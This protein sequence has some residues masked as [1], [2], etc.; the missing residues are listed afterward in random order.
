RYRRLAVLAEQ[1]A[2]RGQ[3]APRTRSELG[4]Q[5]RTLEGARR[6]AHERGRHAEQRREQALAHALALE[7]SGEG[8]GKDLERLA[9]RLDGQLLAARYENLEVEEARRMQAELGPLNAAIVVEDPEQAAAAICSEKHAQES[10]WLVRAG[11]WPPPDRWNLPQVAGHVVVDFGPGLRVTRLPLNVQLGRAARERRAR[12]L[13]EEAEACANEHDVAERERVELDAARAELEQ[14]WEH[15]EIWSLGDPSQ[16]IARTTAA[17]ASVREQSAEQQRLGRAARLEAARLLGQYAAGRPFLGDHHLLD[18][19]EHAALAEAAA[20]ATLL[21]QL[22]LLDSPVPDAAE[23]P[24][25]RERAARLDAQSDRLF[26]VAEALAAIAGEPAAWAWSAAPRALAE[27]TELVPELEAQHERAQLEVGRAQGLFEGAEAAWEAATA[28]AQSASA[29]RASAE[30]HLERA[31]AELAAEGA[32]DPASGM[33]EQQRLELAARAQ[34]VERL[35][36]EERGI[37]AEVALGR[38]RLKEARLHAERAL[39]DR[40]REQERSRPVA[41]RSQELLAA[42]AELGLLEKNSLE[43]SGAP[44][45]AASAG[46]AQLWLEAESKRALLVDRLL[47]ARGGAELAQVAVEAQKEALTFGPRLLELWL[48]VRAWLSKRLPA[49]LAD[50]SPQLGLSR[51]SGDL[52]QLERRLERQEGDLRGT[53]SDVARSIEVQ[54]R[55]ASAQ[56]RRLNGSLEGVSFGS[57]HGIRVQSERVTK[58]DQVL[59]A[60]RDGETQELLFQSNLPIEAALDEIFRRH[61][62]GRNGGE[63]L[64]DYREYL[65]LWVC[66]QRQPA[67]EWERVNP[68]QVST[69]EAIGI[70]AALMMVILA[71]WEREDQLLRRQRSLG[72]LRFLFLDEANRLSQDNLGVLFDLCR[73]LDLQ[74]LIAAPEVARAQGNT[75]YRLVRRV[76]DAGQEEVLVTGRRA[77]LPSPAVLPLIEAIPIAPAAPVQAALFTN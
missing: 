31:Q 49:P 56:V 60:L 71:E 22:H 72:S 5:M 35:R 76:N 77:S 65:E 18:A 14:L 4:E 12:E 47:A 25:W 1:L 39:A 9:E 58:M 64:I 37:E 51:L 6:A 33:L 30:A 28:Q 59:R 63:R 3:P 41:Q 16:E 70:G 50:L 26:A 69:G 36:A 11:A 42:A 17:L 24:L 43:E 66:I 20:R 7:P 52:A 13:R 67:A 44:H 40:E 62:G 61:S 29:E 27:R 73:T 54:V 46:S 74:L 48:A 45:G 8:P 38:E 15:W 75:T 57:I 32:A 34:A 2:G 55:R 21:A 68:S 19:P 53:S 23:P 10:V